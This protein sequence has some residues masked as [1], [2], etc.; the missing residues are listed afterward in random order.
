MALGLCYHKG[1]GGR[2]LGLWWRW[3]GPGHIRLY[4]LW[5]LSTSYSGYTHHQSDHQH[6]QVKWNWWVVGFLEWV[7]DS[8]IVDLLAS[9]T[10]DSEGNC[11]KPNHGPNQLEQGSQNDKEERSGCFFIQSNTWPN[12]T[13]FLGN[14][15]HVMTQSLKR[16]DGPH[17]PQGL[18]VVNTYT[19]VISWNKSVAVVVKNLM[20]TL[21]TITKGVKVTHVIAANAI[22]PVE[23][24]P[25]P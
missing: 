1:S 13:L 7:K 23:V 11:H 4:W 19:E 25:T 20:A 6:D 18:S 9:R 2:S 16:G 12:K 24:N 22:P 15:M 5:I 10:F 8:P 14:N 17:L 21:T 3:S